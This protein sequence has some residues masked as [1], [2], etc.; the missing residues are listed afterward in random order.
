M[1][2]PTPEERLNNLESGIVAAS[3]KMHDIITDEEVDEALDS[4]RRRLNNLHKR[5]KTLEQTA[6]TAYNIL[7]EPEE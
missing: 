7:A 4:I 1:A 2:D 5:L 6:E 3:N